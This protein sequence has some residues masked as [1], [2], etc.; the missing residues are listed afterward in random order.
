MRSTYRIAMVAACP[1]PYPRGTPVRI[2]RMAQTLAELG[3]D[4]HVITYHLGNETESR[5]FAIHRI[6]NLKF[7][8][9]VGPGPTYVK[10]LVIDPFLTYKLLQL[11]HQY[12]FA[13][14]LCHEAICFQL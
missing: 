11:N 3:Q 7:Y 6:P 9:K 4:V 13:Y 5:N 14:S 2:Y 1:F 12:K 10:L 8:Q